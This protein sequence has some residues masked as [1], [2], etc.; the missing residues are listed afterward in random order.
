MES[1][2]E[3][4]HTNTELIDIF[5]QKNI[6]AK[7]HSRFIAKYDEFFD[8]L[9]EEEKDWFDEDYGE[10]ESVQRDALDVTF[11]FIEPFLQQIEIGHSEE[12]AEIV[13]QYRADYEEVAFDYA[14]KGVYE[15]DPEKAKEEL[16]IHCKYLN[17]DEHFVRYLLHLF[18]CD[19]VHSDPFTQ[20]KEYSDI[21]K[22]QIKLGKSAEYAHEYADL[23]ARDE[24]VESYCDAFA[25]AFD[26]SLQAGKS[27]EYARRY[28][29]MY[30]EWV[31]NHYGKLSDALKDSNFAFW[32]EKMLGNMRGWEYATENK[33]LDTYSFAKI[34][35]DVHIN[36]YYADKPLSP[37][38]SNDEI[39][40]MI[41]NKALEMYERL[42]VKK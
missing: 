27:E 33:L 22:K 28:A 23:M 31:G 13:A 24:Y 4:R 34:Y 35:E 42:N 25:T 26:Q 1:P 37:K 20:A 9:Y 11:M 2:K 14:Y 30:S 39:N 17:G 6:P 21:Y 8:N 18:Q 40:K 15:K 7:L 12:W 36:T 38:M 10:D 32:N 3:T 29:Y 19:E 16:L 41:L 5:S